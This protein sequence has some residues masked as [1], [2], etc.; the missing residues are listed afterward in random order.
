MTTDALL[1]LAGLALLLA[2][3]HALVTGASRLAE[4]LG[5]S[6]VAIGMTVVAFGTSAPELAVNLLA[7]VQGSSAIAFGNV[8]GSNLANIAAVLGFSAL[9]RPLKVES[10][11]VSREI[12]MMILA[13]LAVAVLGLDRIRQAPESYDRSDGLILLLLFSVFLYYTVSEVLAKRGGDP[14]VGSA[15]TAAPGADHASVP[16]SVLA[17]VAGLGLLVVGADLTVTRAVSLAEQLDVPRVLVGLT[18][19][20]IGTSLPELATSLVAAWKGQTNLAIANVVGSNIFNLL[21][22]LGLSATA[23]PVEVPASRGAPDLVA[24]TLVSVALLPLAR[25]N[26]SRIVRWQGGALLIAYVGYL[27]WR[28]AA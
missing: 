10:V 14:L 1:L 23:S 13:T 21:F 12:P 27:T 22:I 15:A 24:V 11:I 16:M 7:A 5:V 4:T 3:G 17:V 20:A 18:V 9:L 28:I 8:V 19:V 2:G 25:S 6:D 26:G